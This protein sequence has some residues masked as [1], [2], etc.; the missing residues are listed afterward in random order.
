MITITI[1]NNTQH[2]INTNIIFNIIF[3]YIYTKSSAGH[4]NTGISLITGIDI[5]IFKPPSHFS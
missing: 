4:L 5:Y 1:G 2:Y 3:D